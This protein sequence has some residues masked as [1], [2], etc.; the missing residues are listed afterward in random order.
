MNKLII[1]SLMLVSMITFSVPGQVMHWGDLASIKRELIE[2][3]AR[4]FLFFLPLSLKGLSSV[5][6][7]ILF[8]DVSFLCKTTTFL[9][10]KPFESVACNTNSFPF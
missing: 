9:F 8:A 10:D 1:S 3:K 2:D 6:L 7:S 5:K 4:A